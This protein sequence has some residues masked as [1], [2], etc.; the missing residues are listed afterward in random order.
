MKQNEYRL[1]VRFDLTD[2]REKRIADYLRS[3]DKGTCGTINKFMIQAAEQHIDA[4]ENPNRT[5]FTLDDIRTVVKEAL[6]AVTFTPSSFVSAPTES[7]SAAE[8]DCIAGA[9]AMFGCCQDD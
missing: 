8:D 5:T 4:I 7:R 2:E 3:L 1:N 6:E 9:L